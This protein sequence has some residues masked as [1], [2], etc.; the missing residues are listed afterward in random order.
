MIMFNKY[1]AQFLLTNITN[2]KHMIR[3]ITNDSLLA[4]SIVSDCENIITTMTIGKP[5][6][7]GAKEGFS[8]AF[9]PQHHNELP[10]ETN[11]TRRFMS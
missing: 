5:G 11:I 3:I 8:Q 7:V 1:V 6:G 9:T 2:V 4:K 10:Y